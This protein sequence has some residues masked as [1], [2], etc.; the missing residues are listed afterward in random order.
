MK[1]SKEEKPAESVLSKVLTTYICILLVVSLYHLINSK[2]YT[3]PEQVALILVSLSI[4]LVVYS[5]WL[6]FQYD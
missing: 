2:I 5:L 4:I 3:Q 6:L 1:P